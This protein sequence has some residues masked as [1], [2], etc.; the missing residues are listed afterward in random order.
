MSSS[1]F[2]DVILMPLKVMSTGSIGRTWNGHD[3]D[4]RCPWFSS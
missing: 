3:N 4:S 1:V 2:T